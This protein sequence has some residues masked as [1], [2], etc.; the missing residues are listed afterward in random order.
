MILTDAAL[1]ADLRSLWGSEGKAP[2]KMGLLYR[3]TRD[4]FNND[5]FHKLCD[6]KGATLVV[7]KGAKGGVFGGFTSVPWDT[8]GQYS[9]DSQAFLFALCGPHA[10]VGKPLKLLPTAKPE[11]AVLGHSGYGAL[12]GTGTGPGYDFFTGGRS[13]Y[14]YLGAEKAYAWVGQRGAQRALVPTALACGARR[15]RATARVWRWRAACGRDSRLAPATPWRRLRSSA[16]PSKACALY[17]S[18]HAALSCVAAFLF[19][20]KRCP[21]P[22]C[23][24]IVA[25]PHLN[26]AAQPVAGR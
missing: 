19:A 3:G 1:R 11:H 6:G 24:P 4:G 8:K 7:I 12:F 9:A 22:L 18:T 25:E 26:C 10:Q 13:Y 16:P 15:L 2:A 21:H 20:A 5:A 17:I 14:S 23:C